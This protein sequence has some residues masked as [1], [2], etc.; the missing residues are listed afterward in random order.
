MCPRPQSLP[1]PNQGHRARAGL[2]MGARGILGPSSPSLQH[3]GCSSPLSAGLGNLGNAGTPGPTKS[4]GRAANPGISAGEAAR[5]EP[6]SSRAQGVAGLTLQTGWPWGQAWAVAAGPAVPHI[7]QPLQHGESNHIPVPLCRQRFPPLPS[8]S[9][10]VGRREPSP[11]R[12]SCLSACTAE[13]AERGTPPAL[14]MS[15]ATWASLAFPRFWAALLRGCPPSRQDENAGCIRRKQPLLPAP[16]STE[17]LF[18]SSWLLSKRRF[19]KGWDE[20]P[21]YTCQLPHNSKSPV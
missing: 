21:K 13:G 15:R 18:A 5:G 11:H 6:G 19:S 8:D 3:R 2:A 12:S 4:A 9:V 17:P 1:Q 20:T 16:S 7:S 14:F 10:Q